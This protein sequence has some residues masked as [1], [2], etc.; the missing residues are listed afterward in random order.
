LVLDV[1][2]GD[3]PVGFR[4]FESFYQEAG[5]DQRVDVGRHGPVIFDD[6][7][8][9]TSWFGGGLLFG[10]Y[11]SANGDVRR[12]GCSTSSGLV[13]RSP[14]YFPRKNVSWTSVI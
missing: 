2:V 13:G 6:V 10:S 9:L 3:V 8:G 12:S 11:R 14:V 5:L 7:L 1:G 4:F